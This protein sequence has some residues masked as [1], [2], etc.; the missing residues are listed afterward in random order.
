ML[1]ELYCIQPRSHFCF[2]TLVISTCIYSIGFYAFHSDVLLLF[3]IFRIII[4]IMIIAVIY[5]SCFSNGNICNNMKKIIVI[6]YDYVKICKYAFGY[7]KLAT[8]M[9]ST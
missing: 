9:V 7:V 6:L 2:Y 1:K 8:S 4:I 3:I 5:I